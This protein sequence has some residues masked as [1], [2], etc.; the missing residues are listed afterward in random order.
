M[1]QWKKVYVLCVQAICLKSLLRLAH[2]MPTAML[3]DSCVHVLNFTKKTTYDDCNI[4]FGVWQ[5]KK[6]THTHRNK[7]LLLSRRVELRQR[8]NEKKNHHDVNDDDDQLSDPKQIYVWAQK[9]FAFSLLFNAVFSTLNFIFVQIPTLKR[10]YLHTF[11]IRSFLALMMNTVASIYGILFYIR[12]NN[13]F[14]CIRQ[15]G[16]VFH[17][18]QKKTAS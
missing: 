2:F 9:L 5:T 13:K 7:E 8:R 11:F 17:I 3:N 16:N 12:E 10:Y 6:S 4:S 14:I 15:K 1:K 18:E